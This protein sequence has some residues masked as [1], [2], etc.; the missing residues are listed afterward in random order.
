MTN[1][2]DRRLY[3]ICISNRP[4]IRSYAKTGKTGGD[5]AKYGVHAQ[6]VGCHAVG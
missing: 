4:K 3:Y 6:V 2:T 5:F 1:C